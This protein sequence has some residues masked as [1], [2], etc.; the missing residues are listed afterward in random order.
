MFTLS[1]ARMGT[2]LTSDPDEPREAWGVLNPASARS[3]DGTPYLLPSAVAR[4]N[5]SRIGMGRIRFDAAGSPV[6][7]QRLGYVLEPHRA[8]E[9]GGL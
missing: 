4:G 6:G 3:H 7:A 2:I 8:W 5:V 9:S 1:L